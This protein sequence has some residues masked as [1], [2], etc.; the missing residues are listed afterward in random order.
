MASHS[1]QAAPEPN[2]HIAGGSGV[3]SGTV[4]VNETP[5]GN[6]H[7]GGSTRF[8]LAGPVLFCAPAARARAYSIVDVPGV[9]LNESPRFSDG[10]PELR[11]V[12][13]DPSGLL[14]VPVQTDPDSVSENA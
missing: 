4:V 1:I 3:A 13:P 8:A 11:I 5:F 14:P 2:S 6:I 9:T 12:A 10:L 7:T